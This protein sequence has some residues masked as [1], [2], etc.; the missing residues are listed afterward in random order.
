MNPERTIPLSPHDKSFPAASW[1]LAGED[2]LRTSPTVSHFQTP[3]LTLERTAL[4]HNTRIMFEWAKQNGLHLAPHGKTT[5]SP[6]LWRELL[7]AGAWALT[8]ATAW[9][10]QCA[11]SFGVDR[12]MLANALVDPV[13]LS[14]L[15]AELNEHPEFE[16]TCWA[17]SVETVQQMTEAL[18]RVPE[19]SHDDAA[20]P[21]RRRRIGVIVELGG[22]DG[23]TG[24]RTRA[25]ALAVAAAIRASGTLEVAGVGGYEGALAHDR[26]AEGIARVDAYLDEVAALHA[27]LTAGGYY[28]E[29]TPIVTAGGSAYFDRVADRLGALAGPNGNRAVVVL[30]SGA[31]QVHDDG[32]YRGITPMGTIVGD[33]P[34]RAA[35]HAWV[36]VVSRPE[37]GLALFDGGKRDLPFD[38]GFPEPQRI[39]GLA[40]EDSAAVLAGSSVT[41][42]NDQ[43]GFLRLAAD[44]ASAGALPVGTVLRLGL[45]HPCT[46][47]DKW[48]LI[49]VIDDADTADPAVVDLVE[50]YF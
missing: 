39:I 31:F 49:P 32:F 29:R 36:R 44:Q 24:A 17:D 14:W 13:A 50:T 18:G 23:R 20:H 19:R 27:E 1:G 11:R 40:A 30:R 34:F 46:A 21:A 9:Q 47:L 10:V 6:A 37:P 8:L 2:F 12:I 45:S 28:G 42:L 33:E 22:V 7:D 15:A 43:H 3:L 5:M 16:F 48:R 26:S 38:E 35:M 4:S 41:A 25:E